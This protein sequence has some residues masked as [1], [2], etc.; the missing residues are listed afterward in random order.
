MSVK[1]IL[2]DCNPFKVPMFENMDFICRVIFSLYDLLTPFDQRSQT[3][4]D[5]MELP[6]YYHDRTRKQNFEPK[7]QFRRFFPIFF[8]GFV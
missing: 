3:F 5:N 8:L 6:I 2:S 4:K 1:I 7:V